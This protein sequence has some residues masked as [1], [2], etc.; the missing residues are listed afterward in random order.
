MGKKMEAE[1]QL[2]K[3]QKRLAHIKERRERR[4]EHEGLAAELAENGM[5]TTVVSTRRQEAGKAPASRPV[6]GASDTA[7]ERSR[8]RRRSEKRLRKARANEQ[9][10]MREALAKLTQP[11]VAYRAV[12]EAYRRHGA[13]TGRILSREEAEAIGFTLPST[14]RGRIRKAT[15][16]R[17]TAMD[18]QYRPMRVGQ[19]PSVQ[20]PTVSTLPTA[21]VRVQGEQRRIKPDTGAQYSVAGEKWRQYGE[22]QHKLPPLDYVEGFTAVVS[23]VLGAWGFKFRTQ[24]EQTMEV[25]ALIVEGATEEFLLGE[26]WMLRKGV[27]IDF[28][29]CEM[30]WHE[31][32][33]KK[34]VPFQ[35]SS[36]SRH[37]GRAARTK[38]REVIPPLRSQGVGSAGD[39]WALDVA[40]PLPVTTDGNY[41][42]A[43][44]DY[45]TRYAVVVVVPH[46]TAQDI[47]KFIANKLV[48][49][50]GPMREVIMDG[51]PELNGKVLD[52]LV[53]ALQAKQITPVPYR[54]ALLGLVERFHWSWKDMVAMYVAEAQDDWDQWL[55]C[56][57]YAYN[58]AKHSATRYSPNEL[59]MGRK[60]RAPSEL[61]RSSGVTQTG[62][63]RHKRYEC[64]ARSAGEGPTASQAILQPASRPR[65]QHDED[66]TLTVTAKPVL[67]RKAP[68][69][70]MDGEQR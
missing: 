26:D 11:A 69:S 56:A 34:I 31:D 1:R 32:D 57:A 17:Y 40:G 58:G 46:H 5:A 37:P 4:A 19:L 45:A 36:G 22:K 27:K 16:E 14:T 52:A 18:Q 3:R 67:I 25:D 70:R 7:L 38:P 30:K 6:D 61:L 8:A 41:V 54:P 33:T 24:Y 65:Q 28:I 9:R 63:Q 62:K 42:V 21:V 15:K 60:S 43:A 12:E 48:F 13:D 47:A 53:K 2:H 10:E 23:R 49:V 39:R 29:S 59:M 50:F 55:H 51:E 44:I 35:C 68:Q 20:A 66:L 64:R